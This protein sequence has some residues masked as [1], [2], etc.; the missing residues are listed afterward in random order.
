MINFNWYKFSELTVDQL[1]S[2][3][4]L[5][6]DIFVV[7]QHCPYLDPDGKDIF[8]LHLLGV[9][10]D[11]LVAYLR[12]FPPTDIENYIVFGRVVTARSVRTKGYGKKLMREL[13]TYCDANFPN[14]SI[15]CSAQYYLKKFYEEFGFK[16][17]G[18]IYKEDGIPHIAMQRN[19]AQKI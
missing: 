5:R 15:K 19:L 9:Q 12:L 10:N 8:A 14:I 3:L 2:V 18:E 4:A 16:I 7:E 11:Q 6:S 17:Y 1:Y 13:L